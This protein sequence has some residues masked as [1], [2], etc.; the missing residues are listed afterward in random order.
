MFTFDEKASQTSEK[1]FKTNSVAQVM[2][3]SGEV[4]GIGESCELFPGR[5]IR[6]GLIQSEMQK[7]DFAAPRMSLHASKLNLRVSEPPSR[8]FH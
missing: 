3:N 6:Q 7:S 4:V 1:L 2:R 8:T 5:S